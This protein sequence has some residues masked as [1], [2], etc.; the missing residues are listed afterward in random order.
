MCDRQVANLQTYRLSQRRKCVS[1]LAPPRVI[2]IAPQRCKVCVFDGIE[3]DMNGLRQHKK[4]LF[5]G[6]AFRQFRPKINK[7]RP[8]L[9]E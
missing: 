5:Q 1:E 4:Y 8:N 7:S 9:V 3:E 6:F 2:G